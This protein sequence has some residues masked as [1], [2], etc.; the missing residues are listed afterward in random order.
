MSKKKPKTPSQ[1][2][3]TAEW[4][5][6]FSQGWNSSPALY[7]DAGRSS[8]APKLT[9][10]FLELANCMKFEW[11]APEGQYAKL[12][13]KAGAE[14]FSNALTLSLLHIS[15]TEFDEQESIRS[16]ACFE[17]LLVTKNEVISKKITV[18]K[19]GLKQKQKEWNFEAF[20]I[21]KCFY[22]HCIFI[23]MFP[24][25]LKKNI[26]WSWALDPKTWHCFYSFPF[27]TAQNVWI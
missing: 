24:I 18:C 27:L 20:L 15:G 11:C 13:L 25:W 6:S 12:E 17:L 2:G 26:S 5:I 10:T 21:S 7:E 3:T 19:R 1:D 14:E 4:R 9:K 23:S 8:W 22:C 16:T